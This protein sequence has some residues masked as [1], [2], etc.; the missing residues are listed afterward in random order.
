MVAPW[1]QNLGPLL[2]EPNQIY[3]SRDVRL[4]RLCDDRYRIVC[5]R[6]GNHVLA[7]S[8]SE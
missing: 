7:P 3:C 5:I 2:C 8:H 1:I 4:I 6:E